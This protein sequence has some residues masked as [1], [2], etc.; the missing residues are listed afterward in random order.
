M[1]E[2]SVGLRSGRVEGRATQEWGGVQR[3][4]EGRGELGR[5]RALGDLHIREKWHATSYWLWG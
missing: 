1:S 4:E 5:G 2:I 3:N